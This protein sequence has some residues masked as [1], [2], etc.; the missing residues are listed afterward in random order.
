LAANPNCYSLSVS[1]NSTTYGTV[2]VLTAPNCGTQYSEGTKVLLSAVAKPGYGFYNWSDSNTDDPYTLTI[3]A[4]TTLKA[5][6]VKMVAPVITVP[7]AGAL[8]NDASPSFT[9][10]DT[11]YADTY[12]IQIDSQSS[13]TLPID[14]DETVDALTYESPALSPDGV[15]YYRVRAINAYGDAG[16]WSAVRSFTLDTLPP[17]APTLTVPADS[18]WIVGV[19]TYTWS[20]VT[21]ANAYRFEYDTDED[22]AHAVASAVLVRITGAFGRVMLPVTGALAPVW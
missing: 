20:A 19:P 9:W 8:I 12:Q 13:F 6:F 1:S 17:A 7:S 14:Q 10:G 21:G 4:N 3:N 22:F 18:A 11:Q 15:K 5:N 2:Q 16:P